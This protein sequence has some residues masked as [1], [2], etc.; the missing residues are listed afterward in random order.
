[1]IQGVG[2][3][4][5]GPDGQ[6]VRP[7]LVL[8]L[9]QPDQPQNSLVG[10]VARLQK[11]GVERQVVSGTVGDQRPPAAVS[12][13]A[14]GGVYGLLLGDRVDGLGQIVRMVDDLGVEQNAQIHQQDRGQKAR[15]HI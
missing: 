9:A 7:G 10:I 1:M 15:Q 6:V 11:A 14:A 13:D 8:L 4:C 3:G 5:L 2:I 12:N